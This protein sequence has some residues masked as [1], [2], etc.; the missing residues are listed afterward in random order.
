MIETAAP[1]SPGRSM[2]AAALLGLAVAAWHF[3]F[4]APLAKTM[5]MQSFN[6][7]FDFD[8]SRF[9]GGWCTP[10]ADVA[11]DI[12]I[13]FLPRHALSLATRPLCLGLNLVV[14]DPKLAL[15]TLT[16]LCAGSAA[17]M[18][19]LL[20]ASFCA[21][22]FDRLLLTLGFAASA[23]PLMMGVIP[24]TY[25]FALAGVGLHLMLLA[26]SRPGPIGNGFA[27]RVSLFLNLG[28]TVTNSALNLLSSVVMSWQRLGWRPWL[29]GEVRTW[30]W[31]LLALAVVVLPTAALVAPSLLTQA[32]AAP[33]Q[34]WWIININ[35][36]EPATL[37]MVLISFFFY[38]VVAPAFTVIDLPA[39]DSHPMLDFRAFSFG[40]AGGAALALWAVASCL[41]VFLA[42]RERSTRRLLIVLL[43]WMLLTTVL[44][45]YWQYRGS[46][47]LYGAHNC[48]ALFAIVVLGYSIAVQGRA[49]LVVRAGAATMIVLAAVNNIGLYIG[50]IEFMRRQPLL[51]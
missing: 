6:W 32:G 11:H 20:V 36:G 31:T 28:I 40:A 15:M 12:D 43:G 10:G 9:V 27:A 7:L 48:F 17:A 49:A 34:V 25:A 39:P 30:L 22:E 18:A 23:Q 33:K 13:A 46:V 41:S 42:W 50:M 35:R 37:G 2:L 51:P 47:Y 4:G 5:L 21:S 44:H 1:A 38:N 45:W 26:R 14:Q 8:S 24:E 29:R 16:A 3:Y 19:Y